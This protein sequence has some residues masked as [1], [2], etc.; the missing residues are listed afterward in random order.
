M[1][2][3]CVAAQMLPQGVAKADGLFKGNPRKYQRDFL[4][5]E[6]HKVEQNDSRSSWFVISLFLSKNINKKSC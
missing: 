6:S 3:L 5:G 2:H 4:L 1:A